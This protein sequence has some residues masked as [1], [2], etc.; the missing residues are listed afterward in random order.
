MALL[1]QALFKHAISLKFNQYAICELFIGGYVR[2]LTGNLL[3][4]FGSLD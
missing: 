2:N 4:L 3:I 1:D